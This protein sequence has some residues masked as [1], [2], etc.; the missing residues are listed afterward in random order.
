MTMMLDVEIYTTPWCP[1]C[2][3]A[4]EL[5]EDRG[6]PYREI[7]VSAD[8]ALR[9]EA[10]ERSGRRTVPQIFIAGAGIGGYEE[11]ARLDVDGRLAELV[12]AEA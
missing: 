4:K 9:S 7:D 12:R 3:A 5:L 2:V 8:A 11:L 10:R 6:I 1:Y